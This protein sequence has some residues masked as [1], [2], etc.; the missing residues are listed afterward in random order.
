MVLMVTNLWNLDHTWSWHNLFPITRVLTILFLEYFLVMMKLPTWKPSLH[1][2]THNGDYIVY[3]FSNVISLKETMASLYMTRLKC[4][5][6][7]NN[8]ICQTL[9]TNLLDY[10]LIGHHFNLDCAL[11]WE[12]EVFPKQSLAFF[13]MNWLRCARQQSNALCHR[14]NP[15]CTLIQGDE[16][17]PKQSLASLYM[18]WF[19]C[20]TPHNNS[21]CQ[22]LYTYLL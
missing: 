7:H 1:H 14:F 2:H 22:T 12:D 4:A 9:F 6:Q 8:S 13:Y 11:I 5:T 20:A 21:L 16:V 19:K 17:S 10:N 3:P 15:G 18:N